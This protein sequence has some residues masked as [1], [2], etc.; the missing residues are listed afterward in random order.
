MSTFPQTDLASNDLSQVEATCLLTPFACTNIS[1]LLFSQKII[2]TKT[3][4]DIAYI[5]SCFHLFGV[6]TCNLDPGVWSHRCRYQDI[7]ACS[8]RLAGLGGNAWC[9]DG[10]LVSLCRDSC[11]RSAT[12]TP[13]VSARGP[14]LMGI[15]WLQ[16]WTGEYVKG[17]ALQPP[18][19]A[20]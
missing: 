9:G 12:G 10:R 14:S 6:Y 1:I 5:C 15:A 8:S 4:I 13:G 7:L 17:C 19:P 11:C 18:A 3:S 20:Y 2:K 16:N